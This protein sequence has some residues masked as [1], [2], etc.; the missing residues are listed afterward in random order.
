MCGRGEAQQEQEEEEEEEE[1]TVAEVRI[2]VGDLA[3][4]C[5]VATDE[6]SINA[7]A[8]AAVEMRR[9][10]E[11]D[12]GMQPPSR[13]LAELERFGGQMAAAQ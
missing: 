5:A 13:V 3:Q 7:L 10:T 8:G 9:L 2:R 12:G 11:A 1:L 6:W 4:Q